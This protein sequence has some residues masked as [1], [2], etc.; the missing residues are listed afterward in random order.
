MKAIGD[1]PCAPCPFCKRVVARLSRGPEGD[2]VVCICGA[3]GPETRDGTAV[4]VWNAVSGQNW[5]DAMFW[6]RFLDVWVTPN[7]FSPMEDV[8]AM[9]E[10]VAALV[11]EYKKG[12][13]HGG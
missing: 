4:R 2:A 11:A 10:R 6:R 12:G 1:E 3:R 9:I 13:A 8:R 7:D 5:T